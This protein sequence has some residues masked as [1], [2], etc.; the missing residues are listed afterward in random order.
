[1][2]VSSAAPAQDAA[3]PAPAISDTDML[4]LQTPIAVP[5][6]GSYDYMCF[7]PTGDRIF[8][9]HPGAKGLAVLDLA[10][11]TTREIDLGVEVNGVAVD[12]KDGLFFTAGGGRKLFALDLKTLDQKAELDLSGPADGIFFDSDNDTLYVD[13][14]ES[15]NMWVVDPKTCKITA[16]VAIH[17]APESFAFDSATK[18]LY[19][20]IKRT[21]EVQV[22]DTNTNA[23]VDSWPTAPMT[24]PHGLVF[25]R[26]SNR[27]FSAGKNDIMV[28][29]DAKTGEIVGQ[30]PLA[31]GVDQIAYDSRL[32]QI[33][34]PGGGYL[35]IVK[36]D[37]AGNPTTIGRIAIDKEAHTI[38]VDRETHDVWICYPGSDDKSYV[39]ELTPKTPAVST[40]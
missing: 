31:S 28:A 3:A 40:D 34:C 4:T 1:M 15:T 38:A 13:N 24:S 20:N 14:D 30:A 7:D 16:T 36:L 22:I 25:D 10:T 17:L 21:N 32:R 11:K 23:V 5:A 18:R 27:L 39:Q 29:M 26:S 8:A 12:R 9:S 19:H 37:A 2:L 33:Y 6:A 35:T